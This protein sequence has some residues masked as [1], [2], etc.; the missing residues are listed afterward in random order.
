MFLM[1]R[2]CFPDIYIPGNEFQANQQAQLAIASL[3]NGYQWLFW[4]ADFSRLVGSVLTPK[5]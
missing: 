1:R 5:P 3:R 4:F 2:D